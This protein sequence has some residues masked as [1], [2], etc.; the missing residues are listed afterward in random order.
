VEREAAELGGLLIAII[1]AIARN[2]A[3]GRAGSLPWSPREFPE[4]MAHFKAA[5]MS[6]RDGNMVIVG[7]KTF[8]S[9]PLKVRPLPGRVNVVVTRDAGLLSGGLVAKYPMTL[10][11]DADGIDRA[12]ADYRNGFDCGV[13]VIGGADIYR[14]MLPKCDRL[15]IT[16]VDVD[17][18]DA[19]AFFPTGTML[20]TAPDHLDDEWWFGE[21]VG[22]RPA[23]SRPGNDPRLTF[24]TWERIR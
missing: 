1:A 14:L 2:G 24:V 21:G 6:G 20:P 13:W 12:I 8:E 15:L 7:R 19:D 3:I 5:T 17:A 18:P 4:D 11:T 16:E 23:C 10:A 22:F 9:L